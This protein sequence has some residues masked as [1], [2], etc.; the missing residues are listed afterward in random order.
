MLGKVIGFIIVLILIIIFNVNDFVNIYNFGKIDVK[1]PGVLMTL[2]F[3][4]F[5]Y[6]LLVDSISIELLVIIW[7][8]YI[9]IY[10]LIYFKI[11]NKEDKR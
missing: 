9:I 8:I 5:D 11:K 7:M 4:A 6:I 2:M 1:S 10:T 3:L